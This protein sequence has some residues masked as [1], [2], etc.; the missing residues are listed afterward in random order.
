MGSGAPVLDETQEAALLV[1]LSEAFASLGDPADHPL[2]IVS[3]EGFTTVS[4]SFVDQGVLTREIGDF[5]LQAAL[6]AIAHI[7]PTTS[8]RGGGPGPGS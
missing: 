3:L 5:L 8:A 2:A 6:S 4:E 7:S 1:P